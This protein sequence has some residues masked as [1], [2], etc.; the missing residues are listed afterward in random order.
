[1]RYLVVTVAI[2]ALVMTFG[3]A[4]AAGPRQVGGKSGAWQE[5]YKGSGVYVHQ[6]KGAHWKATENAPGGRMFTQ[7]GKAE[8]KANGRSVITPDFHKGTQLRPGSNKK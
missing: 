4:M 8:G 1:M 6:K 2:I 3:T 5:T 7:P